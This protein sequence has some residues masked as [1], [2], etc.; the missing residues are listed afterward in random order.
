MKTALSLAL[1]MLAMVCMS[2]SF[3][4]AQP[5][6]GGGEPLVDQV[7][8]AMAKGIAYLKKQQSNDTWEEKVSF[9]HPGGQTALVMLAL[10]NAGVKASDRDMQKGL[11]YLRGLKNASTY[12]RA[13]QT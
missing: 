1:A 2:N 10:L 7:Q 12:V 8:K 3:G 13:L 11:E 6:K 9:G 4:P 5:P